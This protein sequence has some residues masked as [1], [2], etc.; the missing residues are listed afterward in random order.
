MQIQKVQQNNGNTK[1]TQSFGFKPQ[2]GLVTYIKKNRN[3]IDLGVL[4]RLEKLYDDP[5]T[6]SVGIDYGHFSDNSKIGLL[7]SDSRY[8][9]AKTTSK[10]NGVIIDVKKLED[11]NEPNKLLNQIIEIAK[12]PKK[13]LNQVEEKVRPNNE[14]QVR[15][16]EELDKLDAFMLNPKYKD[17][18]NSILIYEPKIFYGHGKYI[19]F[20]DVVKHNKKSFKNGGGVF[21][22]NFTENFRQVLDSPV[23]VRG[24]L[25]VNGPLS[26]PLRHLEINVGDKKREKCIFIED[27]TNTSINFSMKPA[28]FKGKLAAAIEEL[29]KPVVIDS[30]PQVVPEQPSRFEKVILSIAKFTSDSYARFKSAIKQLETN[31]KLKQTAQANKIGLIEKEKFAA[32]LNDEV[33]GAKVRKLPFYSCNAPATIDDLIIDSEKNNKLLELRIK[34]NISDNLKTLV[35]SNLNKGNVLTQLHLYL[36]NGFSGIHLNRG[37]IEIYAFNYDKN[38]LDFTA[39]PRRFKKQ[40]AQLEMRFKNKIEEDKSKNE[41]IKRISQ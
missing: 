5:N 23:N 13:L 32:L 15:I 12:N 4:K 3:V 20:S 35:D 11:E 27:P 9:K 10:G 22:E 41:V 14:R 36:H 30:E 28:E 6:E 26:G 2:K 25:Q 8:P 40:L 16:S 18:I 38:G 19:P 17:K 7:L 29:K 1:S 37:K 24:S 31:F 21:T 33:Y 34:P 39:S